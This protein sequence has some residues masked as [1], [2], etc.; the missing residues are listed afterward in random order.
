MQTVVQK[1]GNSLG[2]RIPSLW[3]KDNNVRSGSKIEVI[4]EK[5]KITIVPQKKSL[6]DMLSMVTEENIHSEISA[7]CAV[8]KEEW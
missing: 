4:V 1:W 8:G 3:A 2:L 7:G 6:D 5:G